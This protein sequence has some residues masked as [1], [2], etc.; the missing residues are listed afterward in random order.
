MGEYKRDFYFASPLEEGESA[1]MELRWRRFPL[2]RE[3]LLTTPEGRVFSVVS[4][5]RTPWR[6][7]AFRTPLW[8]FGREGTR[9][10]SAFVESDAQPASEFAR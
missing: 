6:P 5:V 10:S 9:V 7:F 2:T 4:D 8:I 1:V 3:L